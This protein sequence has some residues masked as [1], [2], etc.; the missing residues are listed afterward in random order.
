MKLTNPTEPSGQPPD[1]F[2]FANSIRMYHIGIFAG[3]FLKAESPA[4]DG[5]LTFQPGSGVTEIRR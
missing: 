5:E 1:G 2:L 4:F 3:Q